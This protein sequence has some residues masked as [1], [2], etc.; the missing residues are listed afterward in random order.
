[1]K[2]LN[3]SLVLLF[4]IL[5]AASLFLLPKQSVLLYLVQDGRSKPET[6]YFPLFKGL[7][8]GPLAAQ[9]FRGD[10]QQ[11]G[12]LKVNF[13]FSLKA[14]NLFTVQGLSSE[15]HTASKSNPSVDES[16][17]YFG[18]DNGWFHKYSFEGRRIWSFSTAHDGRGI[19]STALLTPG[20]VIIGNYDGRLYCLN[21]KDGTVAWQSRVGEGF[22]ATPL[23]ID[24]K[25]Y[26]SVEMSTAANSFLA[27]VDAASGELLGTSSWLGEQSHS[28]PAFSGALGSLFFGDNNGN[29]FSFNISNFKINWIQHFGKPIKSTPAVFQDRIYFTSWN[30][31]LEILEASSGKTLQSVELAQPSQ[32]SVAVSKRSGRLV[33]STSQNEKIIWGMD[34]KTNE[35]K[36]R[37]V[38]NARVIT[39][40]SS[41]LILQ[42]VEEKKD[43]GVLGLQGRLLFFDVESGKELLSLPTE[44]TVTGFPTVFQNKLFVLTDK[45]SLH[46]W[47]LY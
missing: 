22:G 6:T 14:R 30:G 26:A 41:P 42:F 21:K 12:V 16:G 33:A 45:G 11:T 9:S 5:L 35:K 39:N 37:V 15:V 36:W 20:N 18:L 31:N 10:A 29:F 46:G 47:S 43:I 40:P 44:G 19:H 34:L 4:F 1:M 23:L 17:I 2:Y 13:P 7:V 24:G 27:V 28:S 8:T 3:N 25:I 32:S 38:G